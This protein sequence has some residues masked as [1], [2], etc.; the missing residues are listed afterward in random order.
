MFSHLG[1]SWRN[2]AANFRVPN[3]CRDF[4]QQRRCFRQM[5]AQRIGQ[6]SRA[7]HKHAAVPEIISCFDE[8]GCALGVWFL[9]EAA[10]PAALAASIAEPLRYS[11]S[12]FRR[13]RA[14]S[15]H[16]NVFPCRGD[17]DAFLQNLAIAFFVANDVIRWKQSYH[18]VGIVAMRE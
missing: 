2:V 18:G 6:R 1:Y 16:D 10:H 9:G 17:L 13:V 14:N 5:L 11:H 4:F 3:V 7:P 12:Q 15:E 8:L